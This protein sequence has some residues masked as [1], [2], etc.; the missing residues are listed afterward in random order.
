MN[1]FTPPECE[2]FTYF[3]TVLENVFWLETLLVPEKQKFIKSTTDNK[4][5]LALSEGREIKGNFSPNEKSGTGLPV[6]RVG[7]TVKPYDGTP[8][9]NFQRS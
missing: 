8:I 6:M 3:R 4:E 2:D 1:M 9:Q 5:K 7:M